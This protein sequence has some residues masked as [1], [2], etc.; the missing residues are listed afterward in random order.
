MLVQDSGILGFSQ[1]DHFH[2]VGMDYIVGLAVEMLM[3]GC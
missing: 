1:N 2:E 3:F